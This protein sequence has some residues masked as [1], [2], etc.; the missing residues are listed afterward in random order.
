MAAYRIYPLNQDGSL[1]P[2]LDSRCDTDDEARDLA[3]RMLTARQTAEVW[4]GQRLVGS[5]TPATAEQIM[6]LGQVWAGRS[7]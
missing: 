2:G 3:Q 4:C 1:T 7:A 6:S 5:V